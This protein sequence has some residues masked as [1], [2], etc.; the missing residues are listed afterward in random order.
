MASPFIGLSSAARGRERLYPYK[1]NSTG[2]REGAVFMFDG[3]AR[4]QLVKA[5]TGTAI[6]GVAGVLADVVNAVTGTVVGTDI[7]L[8]KDGIGNLLLSAGETVAQGQALVT[9]GVDGSTMGFDPAV[10]K[11]CDIVAYSE[12]TRTAGSTNELIPARIEIT[13]VGNMS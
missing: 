13:Y 11:D 8:Q 10:H 4:G 2:L 6:K 3:T 5:P 1:C 7:N 9:K 12:I